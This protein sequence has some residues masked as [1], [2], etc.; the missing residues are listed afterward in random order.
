MRYAPPMTKTRSAKTSQ[1]TVIGILVAVIL[2]AAGIAVASEPGDHPIAG[3]APHKAPAKALARWRSWRFGMFIHWGPVSLTGQEI[4][5]SR[6]NTNPNCPNHG[7]IPAK[8]YDNLYKRFDPTKF[9]ARQ[10]VAIAR[11]AGMKYIVFTAKHCDGF[12]EWNSKVSHYNIMQTPYHRDVCAALAKA[13][14]RAGM[15]LGWYFS[16]P[17]WKDPECRG[18]KNAQFVKKMQA[19]LRELLTNYGRIDVLWFDWDGGTVPW[20]Q[21]HTYSLVRRLQPDIVIDNRLDC[22]RGG[23]FMH[24]SSPNAI[25]PWADFYTPEQHVGGFDIKHPWESCMTIESNNQWAWNRN[26]T[27]CK[28]FASCLT[29]LIQCAGGDGNMLLDVG[30]MPN[31]QIA[32]VQVKVLSQMG[33]WLK[34]YGQ[35]I[36]STRGGPYTPGVFGVSTR[37]G[38]TVYLHILHWPGTM[39]NLPALPAKIL[40]AVALTGGRV[41]VRQYHGVLTITLPARFHREPDTIVAL[42][43]DRSAIE[44]APVSPTAFRRVP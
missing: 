5:W 21:N 8:V 23:L 39:L 27:N 10:W 29:S 6:A 16:P 44:I 20:D 4:S 9:S 32:P 19:E 38:H 35:S 13:C 22:G 2:W 40:H 34:K 7:P 37:K 17:D 28:S 30:P 24:A 25:G 36:Y 42:R 14:H 12:L 11:A 31:G 33:D 1:Y 41:G 43:L 18:P 3:V 15:G 26:T